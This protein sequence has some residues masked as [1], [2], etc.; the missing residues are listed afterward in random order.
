M[1]C[2]GIEVSATTLTI[3]FIVLAALVGAFVRRVARD[4]CLKDF[5]NFLVTF[6]RTDGR[7]VWGKLNVE[8]TG[9]EFI[10]PDVH[11]DEDGHDE[12]TYILYKNEYPN[13]QAL[14][15]FHDELSKMNQIRRQME[16]DKTY[17]PTFLRRLC[18]KVANLFKTIRDSI[19][20]VIN[21]LMAQAK[22]ASA[23][24]G[25]LT[26]Q[27]KYVSQMQQQIVG[28]AGTSYEPLLEKY[29]GHKVV[30]EIKKA[31]KRIEYCGVLKEYTAEFISVLDIDYK[32]DEDSETRKADLITLRSLGTI[33]HLAE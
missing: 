29:I 5:A 27:D 8:N 31:D 18:R 9:L 11:K 19:L 14:L 4:K 16:L 6:E 25:I 15:R 12:T 21:L 20:E 24:S 17:H 28:A 32:L 7:T 30:L 10:Y 33:R 3:I 22:K 1:I 23:T 2:A 13:I 26:S